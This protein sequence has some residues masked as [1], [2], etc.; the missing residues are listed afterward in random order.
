MM[1]KNSETIDKSNMKLICYL[2][3][4]FNWVAPFLIQPE[5]VNTIYSVGISFISTC[6]FIYIMVKFKEALNKVL[7]SVKM[8][9]V[10]GYLIYFSLVGYAMNILA[11]RDPQGILP[12][13]AVLG[14]GVVIL[15]IV[16]GFFLKN[17]DAPLEKL[18]KVKSINVYANCV[19][20]SV[21]MAFTIVGVIFFI[22]LMGVSY[23]ILGNIFE[24]LE[25]L[26]LEGE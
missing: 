17:L 6:L 4:I 9:K 18:K 2:Y 21:A 19:L 3:G 23:F 25:A 10:I 24:E 8:D 12:Y 26:E 15:Y 16:Y 11:M 14:I 20:I 1:K 13:Q 7:H 22:L 5:I